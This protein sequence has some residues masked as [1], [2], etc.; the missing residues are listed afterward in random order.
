MWMRFMCKKCKFLIDEHVHIHIYI[1]YCTS[2]GACCHSL[3]C[4]TAATE[5]W[6]KLSQFYLTQ[7]KVSCT[8]NTSTEGTYNFFIL[9]YNHTVIHNCCKIVLGTFRCHSSQSDAFSEFNIKDWLR[10]VDPPVRQPTIIMIMMKLPDRAGD[11]FFFF[12][13]LK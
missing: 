9:I 7:G 8:Q 1:L 5:P 10:H 13:H 6:A 4:V 12:L 11:F 3:R 2:H